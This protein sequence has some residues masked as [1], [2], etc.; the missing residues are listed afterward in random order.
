MQSAPARHFK[1]E[2]I[3]TL[4]GAGTVHKGRG[5]LEAV[6]QLHVSDT[7]I[8]ALVQ[9]TAHRPYTV[10]IMF[11]QDKRSHAVHC[12]CTCP[13][14]SYC[15]HAA[16][17]MLAALHQRSAPAEL[18][19]DPGVLAWVRELRGQLQP[20]APKKNRERLFYILDHYA[21]VG[22]VD[23]TIRKGR[24]YVDGSMPES[25]EHWHNIER[26]L[27]QPPSFVDPE[28]VDILRQLWLG[29]DRSGYFTSLHLQG[30]KVSQ[31][32]PQMLAS[33]R[34]L[35]DD[36]RWL[37][38]REGP[39][40]AARFNWQ[41][42]EDGLL[43]P[44]F[45]AADKPS[46]R[47]LP[48]D[49]PWYVDAE[50]GLCGP[51]Q[52]DMAPALALGLLRAPGLRPVDAAVVSREL[53]ELAPQLPPP[54]KAFAARIRDL[55]VAPRALLRLGC[56]PV[57]LQR[58]WRNYDAYVRHLLDYA[59][60]RF[61][62]AGLEVAPEDNREFRVLD[63]ETVRLLRNTSLE[64]TAMQTLARCGF[65][66]L[67][68]THLWGSQKHPDYY[69][70]GSEA[71]WNAW[72]NELAPALRA[73]GWLL[74]FDESF[75]HQVIE[76]ED[77]FADIEE[78]EGGWF[79]VSLGF[80]L[81]GQRI[82]LA[83]L[84]AGLLRERPELARGDTL[85]SLPDDTRLQVS[86]DDGQ[87]LRFRLARL[88]PV[89]SMFIDLFDGDEE[90]LRLS[91]LD[92]PRLEALGEITHASGL[93]AVQAAVARLRGAA[94]I[95]PVAPPE[96]LGLALRPYQCEGLAWLQ[97]LRANDL[98]GILADD[99][100]LGKTAQTLAH[101]LIEKQAGRL[102]RP[103][104]VVLPTSLVFNWKR[105]AAHIAPA[106]SVLALHG[107]QRDFAAIPAHDV[108]LTTYPLIWRDIEQLQQHDY[109]LLILDEAQ[110]VKNA[111]SRAAGAVRS[112]RAR[113]RLCL[114]GT[115]L[116][117]HLGELWAQFDFLL[118]GFLGSNKDFT[119]HWR[120]P[121]E[122]HADAP[123][124]ELLARRVA[125][126]I[127]RRR[128][129]DVAAE[130]PPKTIVLRTVQ[131]EGGQ[132]DLYETVRAAMDEKV[133][134][135]VAAKGFKRSQIVILDALL[136]LRQVCCDPRLLSLASAA[137]VKE[138]AKLELL[139]DMLPELIDEGRRI[140]LFS[141]FTSMLALIE[142]ELA[143]A[144]IP[145]VLLTGQTVDREAV[146]RRFQ[147]GSVPLFLISLKAG[148]VGLN[149]TAADTVIHFDPWWNPAA[150]DQA[151][152]RAHRIGQRKAVF[153]YKLIAA[154]SI[155]ER[156]LGLQEKKAALAAA[157]LEGNGE[158]ME[159]FSE[160]DL[161]SLLA[162][163]PEAPAPRRRGRPPRGA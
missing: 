35:F 142:A 155:E 103:C 138:H 75:R 71:D 136:K 146:V 5:Y 60:P 78:G 125:P 81:D 24:P 33:G 55:D 85:A 122:K 131:L 58:R 107:P 59:R 8:S 46:L 101:L 72:M 39:A 117:N 115:P 29:S 53:G 162:P 127:L 13:V 95:A 70:L 22:R 64:Q 135:E 54:D 124:R 91:R 114:T 28:D 97:H 87:Q 160:A 100:G 73:A 2:D 143:R 16:A 119:R 21:N 140:L 106:L 6:S 118:P 76:V 153:V 77:L 74:E 42:S 93:Q 148:G 110:T 68:D 67:P 128:K 84:L 105:E 37:P 25:A 9:G 88:R 161:A 79:D 145:Y 113:H 23:V 89:L 27:Q 31:L 132:R 109:H 137:K 44:R 43:R 20:P 1:A 149:L 56:V 158:G 10:R 62:Y 150:E 66:R 83:P 80:E 102:D 18:T 151:T 26:A 65:L 15:K 129:Q 159:K 92:A 86:L 94:G 36:A 63:G 123:R 156:I 104:L 3:T 152:D 111:S 154:G 69:T 130:L 41:R 139:M 34:C 96:G 7:E 90:Q 163:L 134:Q 4:L 51:L 50:A 14:G 126:F 141:Q 133:R 144:R 99:M 116:E 120:T 30:V 38:L 19:P 57:S 112:L 98:A 61:D 11:R 17:V 108:L 121:I 12:H 157:V 52:L 32:L 48:T 82:A 49:P 40:L 147:E 47:V 45:A